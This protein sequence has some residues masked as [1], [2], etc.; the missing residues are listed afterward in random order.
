VG[1]AG[2]VIKM[3]G[4]SSRALGRAMERAGQARPK[5]HA[6]H[7]IVAKKA[8][9]ADQARAVLQKFGIW[10]DDAANG[11]FLPSS[12]GRASATGTANHATLHTAEYYH[13]VNQALSAATT[14]AEAI[15]I[16]SSIRDGLLSGGFP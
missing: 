3:G 14:R 9:D 10:L 13:A 16:L 6:A 11:V 4:P 7:H 8:G 12:S 2:A 5:G 1:M 15:E